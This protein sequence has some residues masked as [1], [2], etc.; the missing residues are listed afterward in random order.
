MCSSDLDRNHRRAGFHQ[1]PHVAVLFHRVLGETRAAERGQ[2]GVPQIELSRARKEVLV[3]GIAPRPAAF[4][5]IDAQLVQ[6]LGN[7]QFVLN[8]KRDGLALRPVAEGGVEGK[9]FNMRT[10]RGQARRPTLQGLLLLSS[11]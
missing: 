1:R 9:D 5:V 4:D 2:L 6:F 3:L 8:G 11:S 7:D 10:E